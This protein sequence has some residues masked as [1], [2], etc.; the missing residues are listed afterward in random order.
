MSS[1]GEYSSL[2]FLSRETE[3]LQHQVPYWA[4]AEVLVFHCELVYRSRLFYSSIQ[5]HFQ[6]NVD[7]WGGYRIG[8]DASVHHLGDGMHSLDHLYC[9]YY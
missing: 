6:S 4:L 8:W 3:Y 2:L 5:C 7:H 9:S 1:F